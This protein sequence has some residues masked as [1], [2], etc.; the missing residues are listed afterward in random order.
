VLPTPW[1]RPHPPLWVACGSPAT[2]EKAA[3]LGMGAL[4][5]SLGTP[6][7]F[8]PLIRTY[9]DTIRHAEPVGAYVN[10]NVACVT[11]LVC[12]EDRRKARA[13]A[14]TMGSSYHASL[15][16]RYLDTFPR[17]PGVPEWPR[18]IPEPDAATLEERIQAGNRLVGDPDEVARGVQLYADVGCDQLI[19]GLLASRQPQEVALH[20]LELFGREVLPRF[21]QDALHSTTRM[22]A[23]ARP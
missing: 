18:L 14:M 1:T 5:F 8:E 15:V 23:A 2:F 20:T 22:R 17:P 16:F 6:R 21:D 4:C 11:Q 12:M 7:D 9:K 13:V 3:R 19:F 10:D